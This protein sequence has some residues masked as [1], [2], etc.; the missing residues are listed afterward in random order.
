MFFSTCPQ[1]ES[2]N[3]QRTLTEDLETLHK[4]NK[5]TRNG[6]KRNNHLEA[7]IQEAMSELDKMTG[8]MSQR[9]RQVKTPKPKRRKISR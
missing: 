2:D 7:A 5:I 1:V 6:G 3:F 8:N 4:A 9:D